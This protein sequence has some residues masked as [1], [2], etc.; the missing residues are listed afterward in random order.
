MSALGALASLASLAASVLPSA[1]GVA[2]T[3]ILASFAPMLSAL[4][5]REAL[6]VV[7]PVVGTLMLRRTRR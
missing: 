7:S 5:W 1:L 4:P 6:M 3:P 2:A